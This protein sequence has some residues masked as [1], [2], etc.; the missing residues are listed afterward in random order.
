M[1]LFG[2][3]AKCIPNEAGSSWDAVN[4]DL[5]K[6][7]MDRSRMKNKFKQN[8]TSKNCHEYKRLRNKGAN[9]LKK[10]ENYFVKIYI[11]TTHRRTFWNA[12]KPS[13]II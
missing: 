6:A 8:R 2:Q 10:T 5:Q 11:K 1:L 9:L 12:I 3:F 4:K 7:I 13:Q